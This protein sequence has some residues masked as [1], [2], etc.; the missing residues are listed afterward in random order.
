[1][2][3]QELISN[4]KLVFAIKQIQYAPDPDY[5]ISK[6]PDTFHDLLTEFLYIWVDSADIDEVLV[7][8][9][10]DILNGIIEKGDSGAHSTYIE[11]TQTET[12]FYAEESEVPDLTIPTQ[13]FY[14]ILIL[15]RNFLNE[16]PLHQSKVNNPNV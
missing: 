14:D 10:E 6:W 1:M 12:D 11:I 7:P 13:D 5:Y 2:T 15:W 9:L 16:P 8:K 4:Y 3:T